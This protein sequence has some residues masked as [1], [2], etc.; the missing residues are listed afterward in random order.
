MMRAEKFSNVTSRDQICNIVS[1][2]LLAEEVLALREQE[3]VPLPL[4]GVI[5]DLASIQG[6]IKLKFDSLKLVFLKL[7]VLY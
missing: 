4:E 7:L 5:A 1:H 2:A 6:R 3:K